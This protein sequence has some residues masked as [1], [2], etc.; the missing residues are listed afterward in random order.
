M[1]LVP[2]EQAD[3]LE[4]LELPETDLY[5]LHHCMQ[6]ELERHD[7]DTAVACHQKMIETAPDHRLTYTAKLALAGYDVNP[8][9]AL[10]AVDALLESFPDD[11]HLRF[12]RVRL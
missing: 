9:E 11:D 2:V 4:G 7:R 3:S 8:L 1:A 5:D 12:A 10:A 6:L